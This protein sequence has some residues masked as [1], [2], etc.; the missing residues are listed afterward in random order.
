[1]GTGTSVGKPKTT[2][3]SRCWRSAL[4][5]RPAK[6]GYTDEAPIGLVRQ[7]E[8][9][10]LM[11]MRRAD[12]TAGS[13]ATAIA[14]AFALLPVPSSEGAH[15]GRGIDRGAATAVGPDAAL[16]PSASSLHLYPP[17]ELGPDT[18]VPH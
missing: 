8:G 15:A 9:S 4:L 2:G 1:M 11:L 12:R 3:Y 6:R 16:T 5:C 17:D 7:R 10:H 14:M 18:T 13:F